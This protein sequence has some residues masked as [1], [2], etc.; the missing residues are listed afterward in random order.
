[1]KIKLLAGLLTV[2]IQ[3][4]AL[5]FQGRVSSDLPFITEGVTR[6]MSAQ[7][8]WMCANMPH[9]KKNITINKKVSASARTQRSGAIKRQSEVRLSCD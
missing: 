7:A 9:N 4:C 5:Q 3:G 6:G 2:F 1:M 8:D